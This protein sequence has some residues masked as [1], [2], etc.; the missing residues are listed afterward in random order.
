MGFYRL[1]QNREHKSN[2]ENVILC[3]KKKLWLVPLAITLLTPVTS[4]EK[5][6]CGKFDSY[7]ST[8]Q[9]PSLSIELESSV[10]YTD[11]MDVTS[12]TTFTSQTNQILVE[13]V[14]HFLPPD[15]VLQVTPTSAAQS[16]S[17]N[18]KSLIIKLTQ[19]A[20]MIGNCAGKDF[21]QHIKFDEILEIVIDDND[22]VQTLL[23]LAKN[24]LTKDVSDILVYKDNFKYVSPRNI[25]IDE[26]ENLRSSGNNNLLLHQSIIISGSLAGLIILTGIGI[27]LYKRSNNTEIIKKNKR[28]DS[29]SYRGSR[30]T[31]HSAKSR[32]KGSRYV[33]HKSNKNEPPTNSINP[34][35]S[36]NSPSHGKKRAHTSKGNKTESGYDSSPSRSSSK[37]LRFDIE[38]DRNES[39]TDEDT[40]RSQFPSVMEWTVSERSVLESIQPTIQSQLDPLILEKLHGLE[41]ELNHGESFV[42]GEQPKKN[43]Y[44]FYKMVKDI[45][46]RDLQEFPRVKGW[47]FRMAQEEANSP[48][49]EKFLI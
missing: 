36:K 14:E 4:H 39:I 30:S 8:R 43:D 23:F 29:P 13:K 5:T 25:Q 3:L 10:P 24:A 28:S 45:H 33:S 44:W 1:A 41:D 27:V 22:F 37:Q 46:P 20:H 12:L 42:D 16:L 21:L 7:H 38:T 47:L 34:R 11:V 15:M 35:S 2:I 31:S 48:S 40:Q 17:D 9:L 26:N 19:N 32:N 6:D 49:S 18:E